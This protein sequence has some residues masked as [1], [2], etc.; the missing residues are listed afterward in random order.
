MGSDGFMVSTVDI[1][2]H[3]FDKVLSNVLLHLFITTNAP[4]HHHKHQSSWVQHLCFFRNRYIAST[5]Y[6][7]T[8]SLD[9]CDLTAS[10]HDIH[11]YG[12]HPLVAHPHHTLRLEHHSWHSLATTRQKR[13][14]LI[15]T[16]LVIC[17]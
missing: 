7:A 6:F 3:S 13:G 14:Y 11:L 1:H 2:L 17:E 8:C 10:I 16:R 15:S 9:R 5:R 4:S 12:A